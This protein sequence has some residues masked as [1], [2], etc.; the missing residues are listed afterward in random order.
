MSSSAIGDD[1][2]RPEIVESWRPPHLG[3]LGISSRIALTRIDLAR[4]SGEARLRR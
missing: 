1:D 3:Q 4:C 2:R